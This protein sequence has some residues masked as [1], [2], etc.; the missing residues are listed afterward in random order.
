MLSRPQTRSD[1]IHEISTQTTGGAEFGRSARSLTYPLRRPPSLPSAQSEPVNED[2]QSSRAISDEQ[3]ST[4]TYFATPHDSVLAALQGH[5]Q[6]ERARGGEKF[7]FPSRLDEVPDD[8]SKSSPPH[9]QAGRSLGSTPTG[10]MRTTSP[11]MAGGFT[12]SFLAGTS[13]DTTAV[14]DYLTD[15]YDGTTIGVLVPSIPPLA[16]ESPSMNPPPVE[17]TTF[18]SRE[19]PRN[20]EVWTHL[21]RVLDLQTEIA[22]MHVEMEGIGVGKGKAKMGENKERGRSNKVGEGGR[23]AAQP[24]ATGP[25]SADAEEFEVEGE[26]VE[27]DDEETERNRAREEEFAKLADQFECRK[28][29]I[30]EMMNKLDDLS[31]AL[32]EFHA[33]QAPEIKMPPSRNNSLGR[34]SNVMYDTTPPNIHI[35]PASTMPSSSFGGAS[36]TSLSKGATWTFPHAGLSSSGILHGSLS[37]MPER[38]TKRNKP[39]LTVADELEEAGASVDSPNRNDSVTSS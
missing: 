7:V 16:T 19:T 8:E 31:K 22:R 23:T 13:Q 35:A 34:V 17:S 25:P 32:T 27:M 14:R 37:R 20:E 26:S 24:Q 11:R 39:T 33:L 36:P 1:D 18:S 6:R 2:N 12:P 5:D 21:S 15:P 28:E 3:T 4:L 29:S 30:N 38:Q 10:P 9:P